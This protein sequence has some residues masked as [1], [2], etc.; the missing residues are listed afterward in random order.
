MRILLASS[1]VYPYSKTGGL[2]DSVGA[3]AKALSAAGHEVVV[4]TPLY[5]GV[6]ERFPEIKTTGYP[7][8]LPLGATRCKA[9]LLLT[10][11]ANRLRIYFIDKPEFFDRPGIYGEN[12]VD[13]PDNAERFIF[14][15]KCIVHLAGCM[16]WKPD[17]I[18]AHDWHTALVPLMI[19]QQRKLEGR[20]EP[21][22]CLTIH[23]L[24]YQGVFP[25]SAFE[26]TNL[27]AH[28]F[29]PEWSEFYGQLNCLK[30]GISTADA[31]TTVSPRYAREIT[32][33]EF[34]CGL[35]G[36]LRKRQSALSGIL[37]GVDYEEWNTTHN[38]FLAQSYSL[39]DLR[40]KSA[41][42]STLQAELDLAVDPTAPLFGVITRLVEQ[43]GI[44]IVFGALE[45]ML[46]SPMQFVLLG[47]GAPAYECA[48]EE[49]ARHFP[50]KMAVRIGY[51]H[52]LAHRIEAGCDFYLM[53]S[54]F[55][56]CG[57]NQMYSL[58]YGTIPVVRRTGGLDDTIVD[59]QEDLETADGIKFTDYSVSALS[60]AIRKAQ[61][62]FKNVALTERYR[63][64]GM[65]RDFSWQNSVRSF[66]ELYERII[67]SA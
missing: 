36:L 30:A 21:G 57:L 43:K 35:D 47:S 54:R 59:I 52:A 11:I 23:N 56:P 15:C 26:L 39:A 49:L 67:P 24:A 16:P 63:L 18:H 29:S 40:G 10:E 48:F 42:K 7:L 13:Y 38:P 19:W 62:L 17:V 33:P 31:I 12:G 50:R 9:E 6:R 3:F 58:R 34:G 61:M 53:P 14:L 20:D 22:V 1:E 4:L 8:D 5:R 46:N 41:C 65:A 60:K 44:D 25:R 27:P 45:E 64:N 37:N 51:D 28:L 55:E 32:T 66:A 2:A